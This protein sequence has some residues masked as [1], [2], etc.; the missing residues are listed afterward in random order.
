MK[1]TN[2]SRLQP[3]I[4]SKQIEPLQPTGRLA[5]KKVA[6][7]AIKTLVSDRLVTWRSSFLLFSFLGISRN[8]TS[9]S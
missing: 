1:G 7:H 8:F 3:I 5:V 4:G 2:Q 9:G 6:S